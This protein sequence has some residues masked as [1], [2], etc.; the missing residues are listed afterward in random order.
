M[1]A[2]FGKTFRA[3]STELQ[4]RQVICDNCDCEYYFELARVGQGS[5]T[6]HYLI[7][8]RKAAQAS[9]D[10]AER[11]AKER[12]E[13]E[14]ELVPCPKCGWVNEDLIRGYRKSRYGFWDETAIVICLGI[15][16]VVYFVGAGFEDEAPKDRWIADY[17]KFGS[18]ILFV[19]LVAGCLGIRHFLRKRIWPNRYFPEPGIPPLGT[20]PAL[21]VDENEPT[22]LRLAT[23]N[24]DLIP[25]YFDFQLGRTRL[26]RNCCVCLKHPVAEETTLKLQKE[27][28]FGIPLC[29]ECNR[30]YNHLFEKAVTPL[31]IKSGLIILSI[32][33][34]LWFTTEDIIATVTW[35]LITCFIV[36]I[37][38]SIIATKKTA[39]AKI[40]ARDKSRG[41]ARLQFR[42]PKYTELLYRMEV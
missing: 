18:V 38:S 3:T 12:M 39:P 36:I 16:V 27:V 25:A 21:V 33:A 40:I 30:D 42:E 4:T 19:A 2:Y 8:M 32:T 20:P 15:A 31:F 7:G 11:A 9:E 35:S 6:A 34:L 26:P 41:V 29:N 10:K 13:I 28:Y 14:S 1:F 23:S 24:L 17:L 5:G 22:Q 37:T